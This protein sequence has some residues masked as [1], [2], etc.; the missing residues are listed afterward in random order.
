MFVLI[1]PGFHT[2]WQVRREGVTE[3]LHKAVGEVWLEQGDFFQH[4]VG[5][6]LHGE[7]ERH[8]VG[9]EL[10]DHQE[11]VF[12]ILFGDIVNIAVHIFT[13]HRQIA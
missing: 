3:L 8:F 7:E 10:I 6:S 12:A 4:R 1:T 13:G 11:S 9:A 5:A 2:L